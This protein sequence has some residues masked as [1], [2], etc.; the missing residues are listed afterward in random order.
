M[1]SFGGGTDEWAIWQGRHI[2]L[3]GVKLQLDYA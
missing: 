2:A 1:K 3:S